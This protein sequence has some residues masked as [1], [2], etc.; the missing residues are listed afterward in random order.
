MRSKAFF[1]KILTCAVGI[2][3]G[4]HATTDRVSFDTLVPTS[5]C[6]QMITIA[7]LLTQ[8]LQEMS[9]SKPPCQKARF[10]RDSLKLQ[11]DLITGRIIRFSFLLNHTLHNLYGRGHVSVDQVVCEDMLYLATLIR[12]CKQ[13]CSS[14]KKQSLL[15]DNSANHH[16]TFFP[17]YV[18][19]AEGHREAVF[20]EL[21]VDFNIRVLQEMLTK[22]ERCIS[23]AM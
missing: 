2:M 12:D 9:T 5:A 13:L 7:S 8:E 4:I 20:E 6:G 17:Q 10:Y 11:H 1:L 14:L 16:V 23:N 15:V 21:L 22:I 19:Y 3:Q 18:S